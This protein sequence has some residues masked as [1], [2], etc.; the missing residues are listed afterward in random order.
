MSPRPKPRGI[1]AQVSRR[2]LLSVAICASGVLGLFPAWR[3]G[4]QEGVFL[5]EEEAPKTVFP[6]ADRIERRV[7]PAT[8]ELRAQMRAV[9]GRVQP[10]VWEDQ[11]VTLSAWQRERWLG[12]AVIVEEIGKHRPITFVVGVQP[13]GRVADVAVMAYR[14]AYGGEVRNTRFLAQYRGKSSS[15]AL[16][17]YVDIKNIAGATLSVEAAG[18][19][20]K[21][22]VAVARL[23]CGIREGQ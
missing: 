22:G 10:S 12:C 15:D 16:Q 9:L 17:P 21:K 11:Y 14:E 2:L 3:A 1:P 13:D 19:A 20:V 23:T 6:R 4:A 18:R 8:A 7:V 5:S